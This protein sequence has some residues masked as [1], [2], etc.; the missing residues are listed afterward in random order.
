MTQIWLNLRLL[1]ITAP[2]QPRDSSAQPRTAF[3]HSHY[4]PC[5]PASD[6][7]LTVY[8]PLLE[9]IKEI[10]VIIQCSLY[11]Y[12]NLYV[13]YNYNLQYDK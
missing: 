12:Y 4:C 1:N 11:V 10:E 6:H 7:L 13:D 3:A 8:P 2:A 5:P 9:F